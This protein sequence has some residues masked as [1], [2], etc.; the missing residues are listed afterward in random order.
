MGSD[1]NVRLDPLFL[2]HD[3]MIELGRVDMAITR[4]ETDGSQAKASG[5]VSDLEARRAQL[6][7]AL[8]RLPV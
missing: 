7:E 4:M 3:L 5:S 6:S 2:R 8:S 1:S